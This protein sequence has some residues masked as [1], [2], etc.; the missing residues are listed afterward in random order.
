MLDGSGREPGGG[1]RPL[2]PLLFP[3]PAGE[4]AAQGP[5][6]RLPS[7][8]APLLTRKP[9]EISFSLDTTALDLRSPPWE[10][11]GAT[12]ATWCSPRS[13]TSTTT[14]PT[15]TTTLFKF[16]GRTHG[17][18]NG[19]IE[20]LAKGL[21]ESVLVVLRARGLAVPDAIRERILAQKDPER[22][23][24]WLKKAAVASSAAEVVDETN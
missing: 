18:F 21:A 2:K 22:L 13:R 3:P 10:A 19:C 24:G 17:L 12:V 5:R 4:P 23:K 16:K 14:G 6:S 8:W 11:Q 9:D 1:D 15:S 7:T 20:G